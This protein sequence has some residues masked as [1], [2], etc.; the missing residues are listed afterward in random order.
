MRKTKLRALR[1]L[2]ATG[3]LVTPRQDTCQPREVVS[4]KLVGMTFRALLVASV[5]LLVLGVVQ[6]RAFISGFR[7]PTFQVST[8][9]L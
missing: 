8:D 4:R 2:A 1:K 3:F 7:T 9:P 5:L 6:V